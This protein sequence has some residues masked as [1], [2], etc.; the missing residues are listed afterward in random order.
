MMFS[1]FL[2]KFKNGPFW[3]N[4]GHFWSLDEVVGD[5][6]IR[7]RPYVRSSVLISRG[8]LKTI[9]YFFS[10]TSQLVRACK[11]ETNVPSAFW[12]LDEVVGDLRNHV[13]PFVR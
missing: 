1:Y 4:L 2:G 5:L 11:C 9:H 3:P 12:S 8:C 6:R 13:R 10:E 7:V